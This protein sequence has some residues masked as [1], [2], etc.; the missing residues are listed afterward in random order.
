MNKHNTP[1]PDWAN[2]ETTSR[3]GH[4]WVYS[5]QPAV[6]SYQGYDIWAASERTGSRMMFVGIAPVPANWQETLVKL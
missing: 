4:V 2:W 3:F 6:K 5:E 1:Y